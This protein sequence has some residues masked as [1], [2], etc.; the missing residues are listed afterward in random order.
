MRFDIRHKQTIFSFLLFIVF[1]FSLNLISWD[2]DFAGVGLVIVTEA[3]AILGGTVL[4]L[5]RLFI[6]PLNRNFI[7]NYFGVLNVILFLLVFYIGVHSAIY[8]IK[9]SIVNLIIGAFIMLDVFYKIK[10]LTQ[11][12]PPIESNDHSEC[13]LL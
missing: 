3:A 7:Y 4:I 12:S 9:L 5:T 2:T 8:F 10:F 6:T 13:D 11:K 1:C